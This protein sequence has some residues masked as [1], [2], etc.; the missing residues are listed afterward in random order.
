MHRQRPVANTRPGELFSEHRGMAKITSTAKF[1]RQRHAQKA[2]ATCLEPDPTVDGATR[3]PLRLVRQIL[4]LKKA[5]HSSAEHF[6]IFA[7]D[8][9]FDVHPVT[10]GLSPIA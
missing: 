9:A 6:M 1:R 4:A 7:V 10:F 5:P 3:C 2:F 8:S